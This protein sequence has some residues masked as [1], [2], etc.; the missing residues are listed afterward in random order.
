M[1]GSE[2]RRNMIHSLRAGWRVQREAEAGRVVHRH[3]HCSY[4][5]KSPRRPGL[6]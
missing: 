5:G 2:E 6:D 4:S 1:E 3:L